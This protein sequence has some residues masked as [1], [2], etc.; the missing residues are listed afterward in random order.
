MTYAAATLTCKMGS[1]SAGDMVVLL[2]TV[3]GALVADGWVDWL[4]NVVVASDLAI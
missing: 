2:D 1:R 4:P 3:Y